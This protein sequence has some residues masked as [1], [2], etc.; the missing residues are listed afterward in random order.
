MAD[1][2]E[3]VAQ[4]II[5]L[6]TYIGALADL[7]TQKGLVSKDELINAL[8]TVNASLLDDEGRA[9]AAIFEKLILGS[10]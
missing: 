9:Q 7:L 2:D 1:H 6:A 10:F 3:D 4:P 8:G 5:V